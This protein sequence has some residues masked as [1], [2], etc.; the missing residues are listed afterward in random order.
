MAAASPAIQ[1]VVGDMLAVVG[2]PEE[3]ER[4]CEEQTLLPQPRSK[5][6]QK[7]WLSDMGGSVAL[8]H[9]DSRLIGKSLRE[10][11]FRSNYGIDLLGLRRA[12][13]AV[14]EFANTRLQASDSSFLVGPWSAIRQLQTLAHD[15]VV[16][17]IPAEFANVVPSYRRM[18]VALA[19]LVGMVLLTVFDLVP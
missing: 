17:E 7:R 13:E 2:R 6:E 1:L 16:L 11:N 3:L 15:F 4:F 12:G 10:A 9:P 18:P 8:I 5:Q 14:A 19:I